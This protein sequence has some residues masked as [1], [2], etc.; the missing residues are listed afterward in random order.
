MGLY[1]LNILCN[2]HNFQSPFHDGKQPNWHHLDCIFSKK[3]PTAISEI[4]NFNKIK[5]EDQETIK[6]KISGIYLV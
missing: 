5:H 2:F 4:A 6:K 3:P 1:N